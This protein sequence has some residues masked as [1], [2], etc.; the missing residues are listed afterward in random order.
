MKLSELKLGRAARKPYTWTRKLENGE[1]QHPAV[2]I[3]V[4]T[5]TELD[6]AR[7]NAY[8]YVKYLSKEQLDGRAYEELLEDARV[9]E[10]LALALRDPSKPQ[11]A[12]SSPLEISQTLTTNEIAALWKVYYDWQTT[13]SPMVT[14]MTPETFEATLEAVAK[15]ESADPLV[16]FESHM[17]NSFIIILAKALVNLRT[18]NSFCISALSEMLNASE[19]STETSSDEPNE[20]IPA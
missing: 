17:R 4:L 2:L 8:F 20:A 19:K 14:D 11:E 12:W 5:K 9:V 10:V 13:Q 15:T 16:L 3:Q 6:S 18:E 7:L 1:E